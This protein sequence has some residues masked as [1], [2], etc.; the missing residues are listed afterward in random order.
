MVDLPEM[1]K[2]PPLGRVARDSLFQ[3]ES[4]VSL[5]QESEDNLKRNSEEVGLQGLLFALINRWGS[6]L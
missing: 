1:A 6:G 3:G 2:L 5:K 4:Q